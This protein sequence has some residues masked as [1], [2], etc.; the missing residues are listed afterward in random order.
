VKK[1]SSTPVVVLDYNL[2]Q[3]LKQ[4]V[5]VSREYELDQSIAGIDQSL[6]V[7]APLQATVKLVRT[8]NGALMS[9]RGQTTLQV[10]CSR[11]LEPVMEP[12]PLDISEEFLQ[13]VDVITG[14][15][16]GAPKD[17]PALLIDGHH[18]LHLTDLLREYLLVAL[19]MHP[20]CREDCKGLCPHC[21]HNL[22]LGPCDCNKETGDERWV[23]LKALLKD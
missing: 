16:L 9:L 21:G 6:D 20:L 12:V 4:A 5:G 22:N 19:P 13:T 10:A 3:L 23:A 18:D 15:P 11:C 1:G 8:T 17:D 2:A 7:V 14:T